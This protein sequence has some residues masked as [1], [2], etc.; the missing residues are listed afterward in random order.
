M[1]FLFQNPDMKKA[2]ILENCVYVRM[3]APNI[4]TIRIGVDSFMG[5]HMCHIA[6]DTVLHHAYSWMLIFLAPTLILKVTFIKCGMGV[7]RIN[8]IIKTNVHYVLSVHKAGL[9]FKC[10]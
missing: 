5:K 10:K 1:W 8:N 9:N 7:I 4:L 2:S 6:C 3:N